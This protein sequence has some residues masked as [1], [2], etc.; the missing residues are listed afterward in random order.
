MSR[1]VKESDFRKSEYI[2]KNPEDYEF[3][4]DGVIVRKDR[5]KVGIYRLQ[6]IMLDGR[7]EFEIDEI[8]AEAHRLK[9]LDNG[10]KLFTKEKESLI[11]EGVGTAGEDQNYINLYDC[12]DTKIGFMQATGS[13]IEVDAEYEVVVMKV[14][15]DV[16]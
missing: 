2:N 6:S 16:Q 10:V 4:E 11:L 9:D 15:K 14:N 3:R 13:H 1:D 5:W 12:N 7:K 8:I